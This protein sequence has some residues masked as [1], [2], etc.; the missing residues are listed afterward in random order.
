[1]AELVCRWLDPPKRRLR[2][3]NIQ[4]TVLPIQPAFRLAGEQVKIACDTGR[5]RL[6]LDWLD[7]RVNTTLNRRKPSQEYPCA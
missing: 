2:I 5:L 6:K 1:M 3:P 7:W 4:I